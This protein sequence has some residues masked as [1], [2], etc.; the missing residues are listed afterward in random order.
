MKNRVAGW[1]GG[2]LAFGLIVSGTYW[3]ACV[4]AVC[5]SDSERAGDHLTCITPEM[6]SVRDSIWIAKQ[7]RA[8]RFY[9]ADSAAWSERLRNLVV[10]PDPLIWTELRAASSTHP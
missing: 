8:G 4:P 1:L 9:V 7:V 10:D 6:Q 2:G 5:G 3:W